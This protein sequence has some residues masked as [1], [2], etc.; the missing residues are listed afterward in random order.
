MLSLMWSVQETCFNNLCTINTDHHSFR[1][2]GAHV[3]QVAGFAW[4]PIFCLN[5][6]L[7]HPSFF[8]KI[9]S[10]YKYQTNLQTIL[11]ELQTISL[12]KLQSILEKIASDTETNY[13]THQKHIANN[14]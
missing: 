7:K 1:R 8:C 2:K 6:V 9:I 11:K 4:V 5:C 10:M 13:K 12:N 14:I 3:A